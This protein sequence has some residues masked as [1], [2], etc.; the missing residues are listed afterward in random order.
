MAATRTLSAFAL[1]PFQTVTEGDDLPGLIC[2]AL[3]EQ[4]VL[5]QP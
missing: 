5:L 2:T 1:E 4:E 3:H